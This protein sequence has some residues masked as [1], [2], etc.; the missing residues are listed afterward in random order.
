MHQEWP[1]IIDLEQQLDA[2]ERD[3]RVLVSGLSEELGAWRPAPAAW[4][5]AE[6]LDHIAT[7]NRVYVAAMSV[8]LMRARQL[9]KMR[10]G[11]AKPGLLGGWFVRSM[12]PPVKSRGKAPGKIVP[13]V[14]P[15]LA[16]AF[17]AFAS[18]HEEV[19]SYIHANADLDLSTIRF[20]NPFVRG[21][22]FSLATGLNV[23]TAHERRHLWQ[24]WRVRRAAEAAIAR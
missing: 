10:R 4:S 22:A 17:A 11:P 15:A 12:E 5:V 19:R 13:R 1:D 20:P 9:G 8:P 14:S 16:D 2:A 18:A 6:C 23:I 24:A 21:L 7:A 3:A